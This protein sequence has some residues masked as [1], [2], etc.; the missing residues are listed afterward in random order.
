MFIYCV[1]EKYKN[2]LIKKGLSFIKEEVIDG[3]TVYLFAINNKINF[4]ELDKNKV[5]MSNM[6]RFHN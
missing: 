2:E 6:M 1:D 3:K 5:F 4:D